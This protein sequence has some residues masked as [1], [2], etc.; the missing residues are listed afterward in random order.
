MERTCDFCKEKMNYGIQIQIRCSSITINEKRIRKT[1]EYEQ[2][3][4]RCPMKDDNCDIVFDKEDDKKNKIKLEEAEKRLQ[5]LLTN[6][7]K[8]NL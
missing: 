4:W 8:N 7:K 1:V 2:Y 5:E 3:G 6:E